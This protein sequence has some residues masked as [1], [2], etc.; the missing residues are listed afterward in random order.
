MVFGGPI[1]QHTR[2]KFWGTPHPNTSDNDKS[3]WRTKNSQLHSKL[4]AYLI[5]FK[6][7]IET[8]FKCGNMEC[9]FNTMDCKHKI[10]EIL[11]HTS[12]VISISILCQ[13]Y[14]HILYCTKKL[15][16]LVLCSKFSKIINRNKSL[17]PA[18]RQCCLR[19]H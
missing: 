12:T 5:V 8:T 11:N 13:M 14:L 19:V 18:K 3:A 7:V 16:K 9:S 4:N 10:K 17:R 1:E 6:S 2:P 15:I